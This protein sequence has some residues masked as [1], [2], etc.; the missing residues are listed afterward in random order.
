[1]ALAPSHAYTVGDGLWTRPKASILRQVEARQSLAILGFEDPEIGIEFDLAFEALLDD[2]GLD[3][4]LL[5]RPTPEPL[6]AALGEIALRRWCIKRGAAVQAVELDEDRAG[7]RGAASAQDREDAFD[8]ASPDIGRDPDVGA[9]AHCE[10][11]M[12]RGVGR[13]GQLLDELGRDL[14]RRSKAVRALEL[15]D[16]LLRRGPSHAVGLD[17]EPELDER[18]LRG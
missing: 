10:R 16:R 18:S 2:A 7:L 13:G 14:A 11:S 5:M 1:M 17:G 12:R 8:F 3:P 4:L 15:L 9:K 6:D